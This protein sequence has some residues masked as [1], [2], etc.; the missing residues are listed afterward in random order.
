MFVYCYGRILHTIRRQ[1]KIVGG[2]EGRSQNIAMATMSRDQNAGQVQQQQATGATTSA[3]LSHT[4]L[5]IIK[6][7]IT[8][9]ALF[10]TFWCATSFSNLFLLFGVSVVIDRT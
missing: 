8:V 1:S 6:T 7:M 3:K 9:I 10:V 4:E 5:N 2:H